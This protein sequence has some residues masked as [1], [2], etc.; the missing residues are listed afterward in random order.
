MAEQ[1][2]LDP[3]RLIA[4]AEALDPQV[5]L[6]RQAQVLAQAAANAHAAGGAD[7]L[8]TLSDVDIWMDACELEVGG[9]SAHLDLDNGQPHD[10]VMITVLPTQAS[11]QAACLL[12]FGDWN[13]CPAPEVHAALHK[14]WGTRYGAVVACMTHDLLEMT[15]ERPPETEAEAMALAREHWLYCPDLAGPD[16]EALTALAASLRGAETWTFWWS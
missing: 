2:T 4:L 15:V 13:D 16:D 5:W 11:W 12:R 14:D 1:M 6:A 9:L 7:E 10:E 8:D 3:G